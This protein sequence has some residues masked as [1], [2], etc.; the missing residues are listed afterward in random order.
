[1]S[2]GLKK[3]KMSIQDP[4]LSAHILWFGFID[5]ETA[6]YQ[7]QKILGGNIGGGQEE[8]WESIGTGRKFTYWS[9][10]EVNFKVLS[11]KRMVNKGFQA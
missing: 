8:A 2:L 9:L 3:S 5:F 11:L 10:S 6:F 7:V 1:M 4:W